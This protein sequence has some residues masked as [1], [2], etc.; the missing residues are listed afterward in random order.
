MRRVRWWTV[1]G[2]LVAFGVARAGHA[3]PPVRSL[4][5]TKRQPE[6]EIPREHRPPQGMCRVWL[7]GV[8]ASQQPAPTDCAT[9][10]RN[11]P[12]NG[13]VIF[14]EAADSAARPKDK[15]KKP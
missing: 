3:Q 1:V 5:P 2:V 6:P 7:E 13:R 14:G 11:R 9:A 10:V 12:K 15:P 8:P 4:V